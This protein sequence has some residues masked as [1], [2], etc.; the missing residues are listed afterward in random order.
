MSLTGTIVDDYYNV[1][2]VEGHYNV[3]QVEGYYNITFIEHEG[4]ILAD[5][6][7]NDGGLWI[8]NKNWID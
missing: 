7:W 2:Q 1:S 3:S 5:S 6:D 8:D 4:W